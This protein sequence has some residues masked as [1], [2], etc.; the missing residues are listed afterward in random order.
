M[1][2]TP[3]LVV[4]FVITLMGSTLLL[5]KL[6][7]LDMR[8]VV[9]H[10]PVLLIV[11][12][13]SVVVQSL[14]GDSPVGAGGQARPIVSPGFVLILIVMWL[15]GTNANERRFLRSGTSEDSQLALFAVMGKDDRISTST[16]FR[17]A[18]MTTVMGRTRLDLRQA[19]LSNEGEVT[20]DVLGVMGAVEV[21]VPEGW[22]VDIRATAVMGGARDRRGIATDEDDD[23]GRGRRARRRAAR[24]GTPQSTDAPA[25]PTP[26]PE[27][28]S[29]A[30]G[31]ASG[32]TALPAE[33][34]ANLT[35][36]ATAPRLI[37]KGLIVA[38]GLII[39]S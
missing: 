19:T 34:T 5:D 21:F 23:D 7:L 15:V 27:I 1:S 38:G 12:G 33:S 29:S 11:F 31:L 36:S 2:F 6:A 9:P 28:A 17:G 18:H 3:N 32:A 13:L 24:D 16:A 26:L 8:A 14:R 39:R 22:T 10:W 25:T 4:G 20:V 30:G 37:V 35:S